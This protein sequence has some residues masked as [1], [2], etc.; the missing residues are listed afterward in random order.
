VTD[1]TTATPRVVVDRPG[2]FRLLGEVTDATGRR[3]DPVEILIVGGPAG[4]D[5]IDGDGDG[6]ID[7][8]DPDGDG[9]DPTDAVLVVDPN[10]RVIGATAGTGAVRG[11]WRAGTAVDAPV[12]RLRVGIEIDTDRAVIVDLRRT[13]A[14]GAPLT[15]AGAV[16]LIDPDAPVPVLVVPGAEVTVARFGARAWFV[17]AGTT[18]LAIVD[19]TATAVR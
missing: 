9:L 5:T 14:A 10:G 2:P 16:A 8:N 11:T 18:T 1:A 13:S 19:G 3:S 17:T 7:A 6:R 15:W 4:T 12:D